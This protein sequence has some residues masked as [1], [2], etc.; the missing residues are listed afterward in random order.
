[1]VAGLPTITLTPRAPFDAR[2][3]LGYYGRSP[4]EPLDI[5]TDGA[6]RRAVRLGEQTV[7][8]EVAATGTAEAPSL[9]VRLLAGDG[10]PSSALELTAEAVA[11][12]WRLEQDP[13]ELDEIAVR[14]P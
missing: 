3:I 9:T 7:L 8:F 4:L 2:P 12:W 6:W 1:M 14:D 13:A 10:D 5:V 11:R